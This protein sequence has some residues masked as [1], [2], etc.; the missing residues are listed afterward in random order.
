MDAFV[1]FCFSLSYIKRRKEEYT[2]HTRRILPAVLA[3][4]LFASG[5]AAFIAG[6]VVGGA[7]IIWHKGRLYDTVS[8][9]LPEVHEAV[10]AGMKGLQIRI[11]D[12][13]ADRLSSVIKAR[14]ADGRGVWI[15]MESKGMATTG[16]VVRVGV[17]GDEGLSRRILAEARK[18]L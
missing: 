12:E 8:S 4:C 1:D 2:M 11:I 14:L 16:L 18:R 5:C 15:D 9:P 13:K 3:L 7:G 17:F 10:K 6:A